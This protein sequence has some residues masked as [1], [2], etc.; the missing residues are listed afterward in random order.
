[1]GQ[2]DKML[3]TWAPHIGGEFYK[4]YMKQI[5]EKIEQRKN[6]VFETF[7]TTNNNV[8]EVF[9]D[10]DYNSVKVLFSRRSKL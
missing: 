1:M 3:G 7:H 4:P 5:Q 6:N 2:L 10:N 9:V 8:L